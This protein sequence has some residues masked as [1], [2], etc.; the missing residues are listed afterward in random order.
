MIVILV[1]IENSSETL[2]IFFLTFA[3]YF[4]PV[5]SKWRRRPLETPELKE[6]WGPAGRD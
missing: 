3:L 6:S 1:S 4:A 2:W 5:P